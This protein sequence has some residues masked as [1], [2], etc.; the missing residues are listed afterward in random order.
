MKDIINSYDVMSQRWVAAPGTEEP[1]GPIE[2]TCRLFN[3]G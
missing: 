1:R 3:R 2:E